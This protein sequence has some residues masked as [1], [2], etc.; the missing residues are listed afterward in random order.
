MTEIEMKLKD[1]IELT[2]ADAARM[3]CALKSVGVYFG[4]ACDPE[5]HPKELRDVLDEGLEIVN[6]LYQ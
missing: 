5:E 2:E 1:G 4:L 3:A 6:R